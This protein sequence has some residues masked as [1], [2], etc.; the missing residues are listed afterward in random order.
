MALQRWLWPLAITTEASGVMAI[1]LTAKTL[2]DTEMQ[3]LK[4]AFIA[5]QEAYRAKYGLYW[6]GLR[7]RTKRAGSQAEGWE[8]MPKPTTGFSAEVHDYNGPAGRGWVLVLYVTDGVDT[9]VRVVN[10]GPEV[11]RDSDWTK[12]EG[13]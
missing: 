12:Q 3:R 9:Y 10:V 6:Q 7:D 4:D 1:G 2:G 13:I 8:N 5:T 11:W